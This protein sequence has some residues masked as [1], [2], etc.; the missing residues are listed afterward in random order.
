MSSLLE[1]RAAE[2]HRFSRRVPWHTTRRDLVTTVTGLELIAAESDV[3][4]G[5]P[6]LDP[7]FITALAQVDQYRRTAPPR[8]DLL[9][10][11]ASGTLPPI[12]TAP[13]AKARFL[14][15]FFRSP[16][17]AL[18]SDWDGQGV[19]PGLVDVEALRQVWAQWPIPAATAPLVQQVWLA[20]RQPAVQAQNGTRP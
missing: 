3:L 5:S 18:V 6:L 9:T 19:D 15:V 4:V 14:E 16:T 8:A 12:V 1:E 20:T 13:R 11:L 7:D 10:E 17:R 2:P